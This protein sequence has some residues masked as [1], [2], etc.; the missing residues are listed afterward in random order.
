[1]F[2]RLREDVRTALAKDPAATS[3]PVVLLYPG[4]WAVWVHRLNHVLHGRGHTFL[5][6]FISQTVRL[7]TGVE[8]HPAATI[9][10]RLFIDHGAGVVVGE[11]AE[12]GEEVLMYHGVTLGGDSMRREKRHPTLAD[13]V[14]VG[15]NA[16]IVGDI[17]VGEGA[18]VGAGAVVVADVPPGVTVAGNPAKPVDGTPEPRVEAQAT[19]DA[20]AP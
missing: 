14:T 9:G 18:T 12:I 10:R 13:D 2:E 5:A 1:M 6:R 7:V 4:L 19:A 11:T 8:I 3:V 15:A 20:G 17:T 16:T